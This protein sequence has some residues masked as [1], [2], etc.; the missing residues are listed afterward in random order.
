MPGAPAAPE[1]ER[2]RGPAEGGEDAQRDERVHRRR[3]VPRPSPGPLVEGP[4]A[5]AGDGCGEYEAQ[6]LPV[7]ELERGRHRQDKDGEGEERG[8]Q[9]PLRDTGLGRRGLPVLAGR[10]R[11]GET[12]G[13]PASFDGGD[14]RVRAEVRR[15][16][17]MGGTGREIDGGVHTFQCA[18]LLLDPAHAG[19]A[20]HAADDQI[21]RGEG[22][23]GRFPAHQWPIPLMPPMSCEPSS[24]GCGTPRM[25]GAAGPA[26]CPTP[27]ETAK[28]AASR[29][30][31]P[32]AVRT[33]QGR[34]AVG[35]KSS[36]SGP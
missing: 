33:G 21:R 24:S 4:R 2:V 7:A 30:R 20:R 1:E 35:C 28:S 26:R 12:G 25:S 5:P 6:P 3:A 11:R 16:L 34:N 36:Q 13:V 10:G 18:E 27:Y 32:R 15:M 17:D 14:E 29:S 22:A 23:R 8:H 9:E 31:N 19:R